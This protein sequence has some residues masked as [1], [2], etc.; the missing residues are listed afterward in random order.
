[1]STDIEYLYRYDDP[2]WTDHGITLR[3]Q[4]FRIYKETP[5]GYWIFNALLKFGGKWV[6]K[7]GRKCYARTTEERALTDYFHRKEKQVLIFKHK[8][9]VAE[10]C[11][12][13]VKELR[14]E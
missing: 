1:M 13:A 6:C 8:L 5:S 11:L 12:K 14:S 10:L 9:H 4:K 2:L 3:S 7:G